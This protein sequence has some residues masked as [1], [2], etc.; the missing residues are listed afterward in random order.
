MP[1]V[2]GQKSGRLKVGSSVEDFMDLVGE[3]VIIPLGPEPVGIAEMFANRGKP[4]HLVPHGEDELGTGV[5]DVELAI[6]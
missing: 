1:A 5:S 6:Q 2:S 3:G 4:R